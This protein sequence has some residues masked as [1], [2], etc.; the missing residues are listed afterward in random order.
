M[1][2]FYSVVLHDKSKPDE[3]SKLHLDDDDEAAQWTKNAM[4]AGDAI[5]VAVTRD[6]ANAFEHGIGGSI[7]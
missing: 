1:V 3:P 2:S 4:F 7:V 6:R 5:K